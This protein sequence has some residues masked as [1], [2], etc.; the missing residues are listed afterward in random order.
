MSGCSSASKSAIS[1]PENFELRVAT[2]RSGRAGEHYTPEE[3]ARYT[4]ANVSIERE[5]SLECLALLSDGWHARGPRL[6]LDLGTG[7][8]L[9]A[10]V[11][12]ES[13]HACLGVDVALNMLQLVRR[14]AS[15]VGGS[16]VP[17]AGCARVAGSSALE[18][19]HYDL[20]KGIPVRAH[21]IDGAISV[22]VLQ[23]ICDDPPALSAF[24]RGL[25]TALAPGARAALQFYPT[26]DGAIR[27]LEG[28]QAAG[29]LPG[30]LYYHTHHLGAAM[31][32]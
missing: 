2:V 11:L 19:V 1:K 16:S 15:G 25:N 20:G 30:R 23:W 28:A 21:S 9:S 5:M 7:S 3:A 18:L 12:C 24:Y 8:G 22:A 29:P 32:P 10:Y 4:A 17:V 27:A 13:G 14:T 26:P 31:S 6:L